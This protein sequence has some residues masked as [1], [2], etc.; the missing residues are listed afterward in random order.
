M[1]SFLRVM[2]NSSYGAALPEGAITWGVTDAELGEDEVIAASVEGPADERFGGKDIGLG[3][4]EEKGLGD[5]EEAGLADGEEV[6]LGDGEE[7]GLGDG[8]EVGLGD[9]EE[10]GLGDGEE[11]GLGDGEGVGVGQGGT[12]SCHVWSSGVVPPISSRYCLQR[13]LQRATSGG[14]GFSAVPG[15]IR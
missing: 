5:G 10:A 4:G 9:G 12:M 6:G 11:I 2:G 7:V 14:L 1:A 13:S 3:D 8:E 15:K